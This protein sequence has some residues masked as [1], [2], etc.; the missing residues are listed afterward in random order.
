[1]T[2]E[3]TVSTTLIACLCAVSFALGYVV[4][5]SRRLELV[6]QAKALGYMVEDP[7]PR[8]VEGH[9]FLES[10]GPSIRGE[11]R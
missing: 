2:R 1:M 4:A 11:H 5:E 6:R 7:A 8:W 10:H 9:E 3:S